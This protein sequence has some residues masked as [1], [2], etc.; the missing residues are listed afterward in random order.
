[1]ARALAAGAT[2]DNGRTLVHRIL[3]QGCNIVECLSLNQRTTRHAFVHAIANDELL[4]L[5][6][7][8]LRKLLRHGLVHHEAVGRGAGL[9]NI[10]HLR[11]HGSRNRLVNIRILENNERCITA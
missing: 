9:A 10:A 1:M 3:N 2:G 6:C 4:K 8:L 7:Q 5:C 11:T